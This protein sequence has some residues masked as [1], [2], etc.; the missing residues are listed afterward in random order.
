MAAISCFIAEDYQQAFTLQKLFHDYVA[1]FTE[2]RNPE[3]NA[4]ISEKDRQEQKAKVQEKLNEINLLVLKMK[5]AKSGEESATRS[6]IPTI[7]A[8]KQ[9]YEYRSAN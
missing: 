3:S 4:A 2:L 5:Q 8:S 6:F 7:N 9:I 1:L